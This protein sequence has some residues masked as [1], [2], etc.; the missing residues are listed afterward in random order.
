MHEHGLADQLLETLT[1]RQRAQGADRVLSAV[2]RVSELSGVSAGSLQ[3]ALDHCCAHHQIPPIEIHLLSDG[4]LGQCAD[5][6]RATLV[7]PDLA[8]TECGGADVRLVGD[9]TVLV[10]SCE[11][12]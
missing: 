2:L 3:A 5:C 8:C 9:G 10:E 11:T 1:A 4:L 12:Q 7:T 6:G